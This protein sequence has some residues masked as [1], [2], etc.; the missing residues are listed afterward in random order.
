MNDNDIKAKEAMKNISQYCVE[1]Y[2]SCRG[3]IFNKTDKGEE[4]CLFDESCSPKYWARDMDRWKTK[5][6]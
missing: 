5:E 1:H 6:D 3:C 4:V 2:P